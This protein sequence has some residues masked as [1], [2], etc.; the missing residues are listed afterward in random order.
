MDPNPAYGV[1]SS[2]VNLQSHDYE[3]LDTKEVPSTG[4]HQP[5]SAQSKPNPAYG[6]CQSQNSS[7]SG[8]NL[9]SDCS[10][11]DNQSADVMPDYQSEYYPSLDAKEAPP[12]E[13]NQPTSSRVSPA[14]LLY[15]RHGTM[16]LT[17]VLLSVTM[18]VSL[19]ALVVGIAA[20]ALARTHTQEVQVCYLIG[21]E[22]NMI[23]Y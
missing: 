1:S 18:L 3:S 19:A 23:Q 7:S 4:V 22:D 20:A 8:V 16:I 11:S 5:S 6:V 12:T 17:T 13:N 15:N 10:A 2:G 9:Q 21:P 14:A